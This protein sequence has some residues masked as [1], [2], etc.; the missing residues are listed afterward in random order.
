MYSKIISQA[1]S[2]EKSY[3]PG[4]RASLVTAQQDSPLT[5]TMAKS[6][7]LSKS[8]VYGYPAWGRG[9]DLS[10]PVIIS[11]SC[12]ANDSDRL[13]TDQ[14][15]GK[16]PDGAEVRLTYLNVWNFANGKVNA[17][18]VI[19]GPA[20]FAASEAGD[21]SHIGAFMGAS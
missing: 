5:R 4:S 15:S 1:S 21:A 20:V 2:K 14:I 10:S 6:I 16:S 7:L 18:Q 13:L 3:E 19:S 8:L 9:S 17:E 12:L 11:F